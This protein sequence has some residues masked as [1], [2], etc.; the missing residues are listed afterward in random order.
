MRAYLDNC[1]F[2]NFHEDEDN[3]VYGIDELFNKITLIA[4]ETYTYKVFL[5]NYNI[6][7]K[8]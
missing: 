2:V 5:K 6:L 3:P 8:K 4:K 7:F 1:I